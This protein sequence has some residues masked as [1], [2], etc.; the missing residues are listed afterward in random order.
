M[1]SIL[2][3]ND[4]SNEL[5]Q[6]FRKV[7]AHPKG[8]I[9]HHGDCS[10]HRVNVCDCGLLHNLRPLSFPEKFYESYWDEVCQHDTILENIFMEFNDSDDD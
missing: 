2:D 1:E 10:I 6:F 4:L 3:K 5:Q 7:I 8:A 9:V